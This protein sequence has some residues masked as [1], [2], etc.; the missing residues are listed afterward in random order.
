[1]QFNA[2]LIKI[3]MAF[4]TQINKIIKKHENTKCHQIAKAILRLGEK[5][6]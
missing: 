5:Q 4:S 1:M 6:Y 2:V 3:P